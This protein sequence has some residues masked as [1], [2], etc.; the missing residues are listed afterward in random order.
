[1]CVCVCVSVWIRSPQLT[2]IMQARALSDPADV[3]TIHR[4]GSFDGIEG[5]AEALK[6]PPGAQC[7]PQ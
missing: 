2:T 7:H 1:M 4:L 3:T 6:L 5:A